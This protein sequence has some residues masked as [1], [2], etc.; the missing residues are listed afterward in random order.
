MMDHPDVL[1]KL[2]REID[3]VVGLDR[4]PNFSDR[5]KLPYSQYWFISHASAITPASVVEAVLSETWRWGVPVPISALVQS[6]ALILLI[7][8]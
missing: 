2:Q 6:S 5:A 8:P 4:L 7:L 1:D 3:N